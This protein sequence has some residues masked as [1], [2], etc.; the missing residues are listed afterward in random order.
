MKGLGWLSRTLSAS[1]VIQQSSAALGLTDALTRRLFEDFAIMPP[2]AP[3][4]QKT[5]LLTHLT[6][7]FAGT[8]GV[9]DYTSPSMKTTFDGWF[10]E[11]R[12]A[13]SLKKWNLTLSEFDKV[14]ALTAGAQLIDLVTLPLDASGAIASIARFIRIRRLLRLRDPLPETKITLLELLGRLNKG[15]YAEA[16]VQGLPVGFVFPC[17]TRS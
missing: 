14:I 13:T 8:S 12:T 5:A 3:D 10:W 1:T 2:V 7:A 6:Q 4:P 11:N 15:S 9:V 17:Y 16:V